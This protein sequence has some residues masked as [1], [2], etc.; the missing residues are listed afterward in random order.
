MEYLDLSPAEV[1]MVAAH[2]R[3]LDA[4]RD[5]GLHTAYVHRPLEWGP[6]ADAGAPPDESA[7]DVVAEDLED[8]ADR[9]D[10]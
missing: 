2:E 9:L 4:S 10:A 8:L 6:E 5:A 7:Y 3:D 1:M